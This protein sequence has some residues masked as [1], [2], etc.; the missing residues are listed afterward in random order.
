MEKNRAKRR[1]RQRI[2]RSPPNLN[3]SSSISAGAAVQFMQI[4]VL[5]VYIGRMGRRIKGEPAST[6][7]FH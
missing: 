5:S 6:F 1:N 2:H 3:L 7:Y 4:I